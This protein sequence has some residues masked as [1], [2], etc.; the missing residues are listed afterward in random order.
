MATSLGAAEVSGIWVGTIP[1]RNG[2]PLDIS[3]RFKQ[4]GDVLEGK[5]YGDYRST[6]ITEGKIEGGQVSFIVMAQE[7]AGNE[8]LTSRLKF[9]GTFKDGQL[10]LTRERESA[11]VA[12]S[13]TK[14]VLRNNQPVQ[15]KLKRLI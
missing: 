7:Q 6:P 12:G 2:D 11:F 14:M 1:G 8:L 5:L 3:F 10:E 13:G 4:M 9:T 15:F